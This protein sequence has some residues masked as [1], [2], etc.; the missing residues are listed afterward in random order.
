MQYSW[1][2]TKYNPSNRDRNGSYLIEEWT[3]VSDIGNVYH[4]REL[5]IH[6]Y[7]KTEEQYVSAIEM[8]MKDLQI[9]QLQ[10]I[11]LERH[12]LNFHFDKH[13]SIY[14]AEMVALFHNLLEGEIV[15]GENLRNLCK[16]ILREKLW[17]K[18]TSDKKRFVHFGFEYYMY[19]G[20]S[21]NCSDTIKE[22]I[23]K[24]LF[25]ELLKSPYL[26]DEE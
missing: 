13:R 7:L 20:C 10:V 15:S 4:G 6:D 2:I 9:Q 22:I 19:I 18:L 24:G 14:T 8:I 23:G 1:R 16:L 12:D 5:T 17:C 11:N 3:S 21:V 26:D 25:A